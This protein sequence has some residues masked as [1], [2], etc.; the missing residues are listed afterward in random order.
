TRHL[1]VG[2][3]EVVDQRI[4]APDRG[5]PGAAELAEVRALVE[6]ALLADDPGEALELARHLLVDLED[7]VQRVGDAA[8]DP[9]PLD[10]EAGAEVALLEAGQDREEHA[11]IDPVGWRRWGACPTPPPAPPPP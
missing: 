4:D 1:A 10:R 5:C 9:G 11:L 8:S 6:L 3:D 7:I 2:I